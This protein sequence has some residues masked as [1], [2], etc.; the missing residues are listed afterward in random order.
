M[1]DWLNQFGPVVAEPWAETTWSECV[2]LDSTEFV[3]TDPRTGQRRQLFAVLAAWGYPSGDSKGRLWR[4]EAR[5]ADTNADWAEF[6]AALPGRPVSVVCDRDNAIIGGVQLRWGRGRVAVPYHLC[7][8]HL[9]ENAKEA[10]HR[11]MTRQTARRSELAPHYSAGALEPRLQELRGML[12]RRKWTFR[13]RTRMN[14]LLELM[15]LH[16]NRLDDPGRYAASIRAHLEA[17]G[18]APTRP[19][20]LADPVV[21]DPVSATGATHF[22]ADSKGVPAGFG[23]RARWSGRRRRRRWLDPPAFPRCQAR[24]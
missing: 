13:N 8:H 5:P 3:D 17:N 7:E 18:G 2:V 22:G 11:R 1:A 15:R 19:R 9:H 12:E 10:L 20:K 14:L 4:L 6:L 23:L 16:L 24:R 21:H